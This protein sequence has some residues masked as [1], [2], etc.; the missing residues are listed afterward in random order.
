MSAGNPALSAPN[1]PRMEAALEELEL[2]VCVDMFR[3]ETGNHAH[4][5]LPAQSF[6]ERP[7]IPYVHAFAGLQLDPWMQYTPAV[8]PP[9]AE[10][11]EESWIYRGL[12]A[13][14]GVPLLGSRALGAPFSVANAV[15]RLPV[16][17]D[18]LELTDDHLL[19]VILAVARLSPSK[20]VAAPHGVATGDGPPG[21]EFLGKRV[22]T[23]N[24]KVQLAPLDFVAQ[25]RSLEADFAIE[26][27]QRDQL[28]LITKR[29]RHSHNSWTH[30]A[31]AFVGGDRGTNRVYVHPK[32]AARR[33][34]DR[35]GPGRDHVRHR[36]HRTARGAR[37]RPDAGRGCRAPRLGPREGRRPGGRAGHRRGERQRVVP[38]R[39]RRL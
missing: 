18:R 31:E 14:C 6:L 10:R 15:T 32:D 16:V 1:G 35:R 34:G 9:A 39:P 26:V 7:D 29:E 30:N 13:A 27:D 4:Y 8:V 5:L 37:R 2:L 33:R 24:G 17:G 36:P 22:M 12:A 20:V 23:D 21:H 28:R 3:N 19:K 11:K 25:A 38:R